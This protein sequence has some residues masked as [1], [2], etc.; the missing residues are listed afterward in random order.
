VQVRAHLVNNTSATAPRQW[1]LGNNTSATAPRQWH[2]G[3]GTRVLL[4]I[5][6]R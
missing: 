1:H 6:P 3:N 2:L 4:V 5:R